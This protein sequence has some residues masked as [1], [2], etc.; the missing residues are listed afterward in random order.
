MTNINSIILNYAKGGIGNQLFQHVF[1][2][3][4]AEHFSLKLKTDIT[5][6]QSD[7]YGNKPKIW[8]LDPE[9]EQTTINE[10]AGP[11]CY[12]LKEGQIKALDQIKQ[13]PPEL[14]CLVLDG[15]WQGESYFSSKI[16]RTTYENIKK[17]TEKKLDPILKNQLQSSKNSVAV[18]IRRRDYAHMGLCKNSY[19][20]SA[21]AHMRENFPDAE[22]FI[23][24]DE[25]NYS[26]HLLNRL[27]CKFTYVDTGDDLVDLFSMTLCKNFII[28][29]SSY[30]WWG[31][32]FGENAVSTNQENIIIAPFE[33]TTIDETPSPCPSRWTLL[34]NSVEPFIVDHDEVSSQIKKYN[35]LDSIRQY[36][37]G[38]P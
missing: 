15:Y 31:A 3:S 9:A 37:I 33:W 5:Y 14:R 10:H 27:D 6:F 38:F 2:S 23:Y 19:Y 1:A 7:P 8:M 13:L 11:G 16:A 12:L 34:P 21:I 29:N 24:T 36:G 35:G 28:S 26:K 20:L 25:K 22:F 32:W 17:I 4:V 30:S 18:H